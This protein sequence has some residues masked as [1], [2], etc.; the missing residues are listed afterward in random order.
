[1][2][3]VKV[4]KIILISALIL[5]LGGCGKPKKTLFQKTELD[6]G[7]NTLCSLSAYTADEAEFDRYFTKMVA[8]FAYYH[9]LFDI[10]HDYAG[11]NNLKTVNDNAGKQAVKTDKALI[12]MLELAKEI[13]TLSYGVF[14]ITDGALLKIWHNYRTLGNDLNSNGEYGKIPTQKELEAVRQNHGFDKLI[15][16][17]EADTVYLSDPQVSLDVGGIA[18]GF[19][20][21]LIAEELKAEGL[22]NGAVNGG[23]NQKI[24]GSKPDGSG[25]NVGIQDPRAKS[26]AGMITSSSIALLPDLKDVAIVTSGDYQNFY[27]AEGNRIMAHII[28]PTTLYPARHYYS[29]TVI[30]ADSGLADCLSTA[31]FILDFAAG[32]ELIKTCEEKYQTEIKALYVSETALNAKSFRASVNPEEFLT[33]SA[34][35]SDVVINDK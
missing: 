5:N 28:D 16:D 33:P 29:V 14:D 22:T 24:I 17:H 32:Q 9:K 18:K 10:Y 1:M 23:G 8:E 26:L 20:V 7:F 3:I 31:L 19:T 4:G 34:K 13:N 6:C 30:T 12:K 27:I 2:R 21:E 35:L 11:I 15:I 25:F